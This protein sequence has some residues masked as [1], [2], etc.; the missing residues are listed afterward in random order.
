MKDGM[1]FVQ[2]VGSQQ[3][4]AGET[5]ANFD[6]S[7]KHIRICVEFVQ[8]RNRH[9]LGNSTKSKDFDTLQLGHVCKTIGPQFKSIS[10][11]FI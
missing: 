8:G 1:Q 5:F 9:D 11:E 6:Y 10:D 7:S 2:I 4:F 3:K